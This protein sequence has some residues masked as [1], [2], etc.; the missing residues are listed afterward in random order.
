MK[1][2]VLLIIGVALTTLFSSC[3]NDEVELIGNWEQKS[4]Y[5]GY[6]RAE[7][8][9]FAINNFGYF[10]MGHDDD[11]NLSDFWK[12]D[13]SSNSWIPAKSFPGTA[14]AYNVSVSNGQ[15]GYVGLGYDGS[16]DLSD[17]WEYDPTSNSWNRIADFP[18]GP[19]RYATAFAIGTD[20]YVGTGTT[21]NDKQYNNDFY[22]YDG[23]NWT[24]IKSL[25]GNKRRKANSTGFEGK[26]YVISG[27]RSS[28][29]L[30]DMWVYDPANDSWT[31][32]AR[33]DNEDTGNTAIPRQNAVLF[34]SDGRL[35]ITTGSQGNTT[36]T[37]TYEWNPKTEEWTERTSFEGSIREGAGCFVINDKGYI[38]GGRS[39]A[40]YKDDTFKFE[41]NADRDSND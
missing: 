30:N 32:K 13:P 40:S 34:G 38:V 8:S 14:R 41:P 26:G 18:G 17:F 33:I 2:K 10:G 16:N 24:Q 25:P 4:W 22:K 39:G 37:S 28:T 5:D 29:I 15:K 9:S 1:L 31:E 3:N 36:T 12:Y 21:D 6:A 20:I 27:S 11:G 35:F 23:N 7:G 19:R